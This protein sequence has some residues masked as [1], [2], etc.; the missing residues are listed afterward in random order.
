MQWSSAS[1]RLSRRHGETLLLH[2]LRWVSNSET[3]AQTQLLPQHSCC[4]GSRSMHAGGMVASLVH[5]RSL[6]VGAAAAARCREFDAELEVAFDLL[7]LLLLLLLLPGGASLML[8]WK[9]RGSGSLTQCC[10]T[11]SQQ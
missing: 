8:S 1:G 11:T 7:F 2:V 4:L 6:L 10:A 5:R 3:T 9:Q